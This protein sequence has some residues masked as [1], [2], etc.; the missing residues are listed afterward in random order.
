MLER[1]WL[2]RRKKQAV[3]GFGLGQ[4]LDIPISPRSVD[5][6]SLDFVGHG[7]RNG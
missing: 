1:P 3:R 6:L 4:W 5:G 7:R 2:I